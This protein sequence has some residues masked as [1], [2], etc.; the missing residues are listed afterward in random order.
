[1]GPLIPTA[2]PPCNPDLTNRGHFLFEAGGR[3][4]VKS[5]QLGVGV[6]ADRGTERQEATYPRRVAGP[7]AVFLTTG[8]LL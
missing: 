6:V 3:Y 2:T 8:I 7:E 5:L 4:S 1:M